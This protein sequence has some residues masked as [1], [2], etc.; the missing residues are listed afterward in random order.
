MVDTAPVE[1]VGRDGEVS[2][3]VESAVKVTFAG[4]RLGVGSRQCSLQLKRSAQM[5][6]RRSPLS[7]QGSGNSPMG[8]W[9]TCPVVLTYSNCAQ[10]GHTSSPGHSMNTISE[11]HVGHARDLPAAPPSPMSGRSITYRTP[12]RSVAAGDARVGQHRRLR[13]PLG[14]LRDKN[15]REACGWAE[16]VRG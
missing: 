10:P 5:R 7:D 1:L 4:R 3:L 2:A 13:E 16:R 9:D 8:A 6:L 12:R 11:P 15:V 14:L